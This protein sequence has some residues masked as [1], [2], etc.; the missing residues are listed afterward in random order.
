MRISCGG[1]T[2]VRSIGRD[3]GRALASAAHRTALTRTKHGEFAVLD[4]IAPED[5]GNAPVILSAMRANDETFTR[6]VGA[7]GEGED[8]AERAVGEGKGRQ[9]APVAVTCKFCLQV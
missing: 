8:G 2:Y 7:G 5:A 4:C 3:L 6:L 9:H 1:G